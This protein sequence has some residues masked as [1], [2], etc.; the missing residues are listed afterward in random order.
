MQRRDAAWLLLLVGDELS[1][2]SARRRLN[3]RVATGRRRTV[4]AA[5]G[6]TRRHGRRSRDVSDRSVT[7]ACWLN[8]ESATVRRMMTP[9]RCTQKI[10]RVF[11]GFSTD[12]LCCPE[13]VT[14]KGFQL[15]P[16]LRVFLK[17]TLFKGFS[18]KNPFRVFFQ[19][20]FR[21]LRV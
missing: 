7:R 15:K 3:R 16:F 12:F 1:T 5:T 6:Q 17:K 11:K 10:K 9:R 21:V 20:P 14:L 13:E 19:K 18:K 2:E 8:E 4:K